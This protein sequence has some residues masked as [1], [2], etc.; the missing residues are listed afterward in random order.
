MLLRC[1][2]A[3]CFDCLVVILFDVLHGCS[4]FL[5][6]YL[7]VSTFVLFLNRLFDYFLWGF[8]FVCYMFE[9]LLDS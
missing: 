6:V 2:L 8:L 1:Y 4:Y 3:N 9:H 5:L 7:F